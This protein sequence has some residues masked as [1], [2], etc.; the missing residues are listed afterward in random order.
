MLLKH[1]PIRNRLLPL[2]LVALAV[3][4]A[5]RPQSAESGPDAA[6][7]GSL[8]DELGRMD[9][10]FFGALFAD[11]DAAAANAL[12]SEDVEFYDDRTG[13]STGDEV[14]E[15]FERLAADCPAENGV[16]RVLLPNSVEV[17]PIHGI[18]ALQTG[19][20]HFVE[21]NA[22]SSTIA[23]FYVIWS[24]GHGTWK[25]SRIMSVDHEIVDAADAADL[26]RDAS[27]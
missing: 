4:A 12:L 2:A 23:R 16:R 1:S 11:C 5:A 25:M 17:Y 18:G 8:R 15:G 22:S 7:I 6:A 3:P 21:S 9:R 10:I 14:R 19:I 20:H 26:H 13:L 27:S 24:N